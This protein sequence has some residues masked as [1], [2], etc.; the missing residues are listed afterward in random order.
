[1]T[2]YLLPSRMVVY[3]SPSAS[4]PPLEQRLLPA[5]GLPSQLLQPAPMSVDPVTRCVLCCRNWLLWS[6]A[7]SAHCVGAAAVKC[8]A[9]M[10]AASATLNRC[11]FPRKPSIFAIR[12]PQQQAAGMQQANIARHPPPGSWTPFGGDTA[13]NGDTRHL[14]FSG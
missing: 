2:I 14:L 9:V 3:R 8:N 7:R 6:H 12:S 4:P 13:A 5:A 11:M 1:M 10:H